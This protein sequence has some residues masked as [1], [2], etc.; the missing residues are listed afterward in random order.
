MLKEREKLEAYITQKDLELLTNI[1]TQEYHKRRVV[2]LGNIN[3]LI[4]KQVQ[5][6]REELK[7]YAL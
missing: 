4:Q 1:E 7:R 5:I 3:R 2:E 6:A